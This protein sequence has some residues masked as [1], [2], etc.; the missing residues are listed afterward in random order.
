MVAEIKRKVKNKYGCLRDRIRT[1]TVSSPIS[2]PFDVHGLP[3]WVKEKFTDTEGNLGRSSYCTSTSR[4]RRVWCCACDVWRD[5]RRRTGLYPTAPWMISGI[6]S[7]RFSARG[8]LRWFGCLIVFIILPPSAISALCSA[9]LPLAG[10]VIFLV[11]LGGRRSTSTSSTLW[12][13]RSSLGLVWIPLST[14]CTD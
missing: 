3:D 13:C 10:F 5:P 6:C 1:P 9:Y 12:S 2:T 8:P 7:R 11:S 14:W 4:H